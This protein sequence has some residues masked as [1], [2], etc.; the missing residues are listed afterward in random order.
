MPP[1][2]YTITF[3]PL[4]SNPAIFTS[5][6]HN[7]G[8]SSTLKFA[9][10]YDLDVMPEEEVLAYVLAFPTGEGYDE[11]VS[12]RET[13]DIDGKQAEE[14][15]DGKV[16]WLRQ[17]IHNACGLYA[18][19]HATCNGAA[20]KHISIHFPS[21]STFLLRLT[22]DTE[23]DSILHKLLTTPPSLQ[24]SFLSSNTDLETFYTAAAKQ[25][26]TATPE[27]NVEVDWHY[28]CFVPNPDMH[29]LLE[30]DG[31]RWGPLERGDLA[32]DVSDFGLKA[33]EVIK[34]DYFE[35]V[36]EGGREGMFSVLALVR[37]KI[38]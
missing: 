24:S 22:P 10:V 37:E 18:L 8:L 38:G 30:L 7:L 21:R 19:L 25:G 16:L 36:E 35:K 27:E 32:Q 5:L 28:T 14:N 29:M 9:E 31:D 4:E 33:R 12:R 2:T 6:A 34:K 3:L 23:S 1:R 26:D 13:G 20:R 11:E 17:T 15:E